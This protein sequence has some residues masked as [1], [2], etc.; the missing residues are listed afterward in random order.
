MPIPFTPPMECLPVKKL[1][2]GPEWAYELKLDGYR[3]QAIREADGL[4][5]L[6]SNGKDLGV[7]TVTKDSAGVP[8][9]PL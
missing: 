3:A 7:R 4:R 1:P 8:K 5:L 9:A 2:D 6:S